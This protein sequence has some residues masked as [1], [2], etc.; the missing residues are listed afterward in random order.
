MSP[1]PPRCAEP[2]CQMHASCTVPADSGVEGEY[3]HICK[4]HYSVWS[5][6]QRAKAALDKADQGNP[7]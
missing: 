6:A 7:Q 3:K 4:N 5:D 2:G 1:A